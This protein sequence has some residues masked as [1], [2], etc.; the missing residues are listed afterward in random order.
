[1]KDVGHLWMKY[2]DVNKGDKTNYFYHVNYWRKYI[3]HYTIDEAMHGL[4]FISDII[5]EIVWYRCFNET[6]S[7]DMY[8][9]L[10]V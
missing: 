8:L 10:K 7:T 4:K 2:V 9:W 5:D 3:Y 6:V 1:M